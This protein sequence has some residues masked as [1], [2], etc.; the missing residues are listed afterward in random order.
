MVVFRIRNRLDYGR[1]AKLR[2]LTVPLGLSLA[3][4]PLPGVRASAGPSPPVDSR[5]FF[6][7]RAHDVV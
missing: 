7:S 2:A 5:V 3:L 1:Q 4:S 6:S